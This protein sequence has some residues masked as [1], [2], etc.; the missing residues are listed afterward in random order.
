MLLCILASA[1]LLVASSACAQE[2]LY[3]WVDENGNVTYQSQPPPAN[4]GQVETLESIGDTGARAPSPD[5]NVVLYSIKVC[6]ACDLVRNLLTEWRVPFAEKNADG[7]AK[8]QAEL[9]K[10][11]GKLSVPALLIGDEVLMGYN[12]ALIENELK[13]VGFSAGLPATATPPKQTPEPHKLTRE[14]LAGMTPE[15]IEQAARDAALRGID[16]DLF[17]E[18][19][20]FATLNEDVL[21]RDDRTPP[22]GV[23]EAGPSAEGPSASTDQ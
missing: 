4:A 13:E 6:D 14:D 19:A 20:G 23:Y 10:V 9:K 22:D 15:E 7:D 3:K 21:H 16:N 18:D 11:A 5:V 8:V 17:E 2:K 1:C 12:K